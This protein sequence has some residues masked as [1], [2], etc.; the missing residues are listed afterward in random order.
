MKSDHQLK[1]NIFLLLF[2]I[3]VS[4]IGDFIYLV[5]LNVFILEQT[6]SALAVAG[7][8][9]AGRIAS[10]IVSPWAGSIS[11]RLS[12]RKQLIFIEMTRGML[13]GII[14]FA[15]NMDITYIIL[16]FL[17]ALGIFFNNVFLPYQ[18]ALFPG[19]HRKTVNSLST[20][21]RYGAFLIGPAVAG[22]LLE[23][24]NP[25]LPFWM[26][27]FSFIISGVVFMSL[28]ETANH[29]RERAEVLKSVEKRHWMKVVREDWRMVI[30]F[31]RSHIFFSILYLLHTFIMILALLADSQE[32]VFAKEALQLE[33]SGYSLMV[34][35]AG[36]GFV[37]GSLILTFVAKQIRT[38]WLIGIG[39]FLSAFGYLVYALAPNLYW[40]VGGLLILGLFGAMASVGFTTYIQSQVPVSIMG[41]INNVMGS[42]QQ[43]LGILFILLGG[44]LAS[45]FGV[46]TLMVSSTLLMFILSVLLSGM[47]LSRKRSTLV[48]GEIM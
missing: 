13:V 1:V 37:V 26:D 11:D 2:G 47:V 35:S 9:V 20:F 30:S 32:V 33:D 25:I 24:G 6:G 28:P 17:G 40:A 36:M 31:L 44:F 27:A 29:H 41:R 48:K 39:R 45:E 4:G 15:N 23:I 14:P 22:F 38:K 10:L 46:R 19:E 18:T 34:F 12:H 16:F 5:A 7:I 42:F 8:W 21:L 43:G 3:G